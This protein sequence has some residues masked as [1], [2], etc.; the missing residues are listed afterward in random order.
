MS[1]IE[2]LCWFRQY[3][4]WYIEIGIGKCFTEH[5]IEMKYKTRHLLELL[6]ILPIRSIEDNAA[7]ERCRIL[8][9]CVVHK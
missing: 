7:A 5:E 9:V 2:Q 3:P 4:K 6:T 8:A 1:N